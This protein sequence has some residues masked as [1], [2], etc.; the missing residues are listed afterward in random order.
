MTLMTLDVAG[1]DASLFVAWRVT[2]SL[3]VAGCP[4]VAVRETPY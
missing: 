2:V 4:V 1:A 3:S